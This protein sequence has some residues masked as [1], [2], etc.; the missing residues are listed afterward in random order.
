MKTR[1]P[2]TCMCLRSLSYDSDG[3]RAV[4]RW[5]QKT[6]RLVQSGDTASV[7][8]NWE[9]TAQEIWLIVGDPT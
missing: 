6:I 3:D 9:R 5:L 1:F 8:P 2:L 4:H 7:R